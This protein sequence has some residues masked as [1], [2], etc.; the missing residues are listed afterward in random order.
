MMCSR[1]SVILLF[2]ILIGCTNITKKID[3]LAKSGNDVE[4]CKII[5][6]YAKNED[7]YKKSSII[8]KCIDVIFEN[9][10]K[11]T[12]IKIES[13]FISGDLNDDIIFHMAKSYKINTKKLDNQE[14]VLNK[15]FK[16]ELFSSRD[17]NIAIV[18]NAISHKDARIYCNELI[19]DNIK[20]I[21]IDGVLKNTK[22]LQ[23]I[24]NDVKINENIKMLES[25]YAKI[26]N[27]NTGI[28]ELE[29]ITKEL[30]DELKNTCAEYDKLR[31]SQK[32]HR[33]ISCYIVGMFGYGQYEAV[34]N[35]GRCLLFTLENHMMDDR[36]SA[37]VE[38]I[39]DTVMKIQPQYGGGMAI[40]PT[41]REI[42]VAKF[43]KN[44]KELMISKNDISKN[45]KKNEIESKKKEN[46]MR[47]YSQNCIE[48]TNEIKLINNYQ[49]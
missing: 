6:E 27:N 34:G 45:I 10:L 11:N 33:A 5:D 37:V 48:I 2:L 39:D 20:N 49:K 38:K 25:N 47:L 43:E 30:K 4:I 36:Y 29:K 18:S 9:N 17:A 28:I 16:D 24:I 26:A 8:K 1:K 22:L 3:K 31:L 21:D 15:F 12:K 46:E 40:Y 42:D 13:M 23:K 19:D 7:I 35:L 41:Y 14:M 44:M 32:N